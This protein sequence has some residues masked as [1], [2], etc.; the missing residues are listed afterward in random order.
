M[1][2]CRLGAS[3][4]ASVDSAGHK[5]IYSQAFD[6]HLCTALCNDRA[7]E[8]PAKLRRLDAFRRSVPHVTATALATIL[9]HAL[10]GVPELGM[11]R[12]SLRHARDNTLSEATPYGTLMTSAQL[13]R[14]DGTFHTLHFV[15]PFVHL[16]LAVK[17][18]RGLTNLLV[19]Q[20]RAKPCTQ[21]DPWCL[22]LYSDEVV[23]GNQLSAHNMRKVWAMYWSIIELGHAFLADEDGWFCTVSERTENVKQ[24]GG[25]IASVFGALLKHMFATGGHTFQTSGVLLDLFDGTQ[26]PSKHGRPTN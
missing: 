4:H 15:D 13:E 16:Y 25:G 9:T 21:A 3:A 22:V 2:A 24:L 8:R 5:H 17:K 7:M 11:S 6:I 20:L 10:L 1:Q 23:P 14:V 26:V 18:S 19:N 12:H